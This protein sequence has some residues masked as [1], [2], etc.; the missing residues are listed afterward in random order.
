MH[1]SFPCPNPTCTHTFSP[2]VVKGATSLKCPCCGSVFQFSSAAPAAPAPVK[3]VEPPRPKP[4]IAIPKAPPPRPSATVP[5][6]QPAAAPLPVAA[7]VASAPASLNFNSQPDMVVPRARRQTASK[8][9]RLLPRIALVVAGLVAVVLTIWG[10]KRLLHW[11]NTSSDDPA[12]VAEAY[13]CQFAWPPKPWTRQP[14]IQQ[15]LHVHIA[16]TAPQHNA[17]V[18]LFFRDYKTRMPSDAEMLDEALT[19]LRSYLRRLEWEKK[20]N[21]DKVQ[22]A[23]HPAKA[24]EFQGDDAEEVTM[25]GECLMLAWRGYGYW[26]FSWAPHGELRQHEE[27]IHAEWTQVRQRLTLQNGRKGWAPKAPETET[28]TGTKVKHQLAALKGLW[29][30]ESAED[31][32]PSADLVL[33]G[34]YPEDPDRK[35]QAGKDALFQVLVLPKQDNLKAAVA[36]ARE[37]VK[38]REETLYPGT[39]IEAIKDKNDEADRDTDVGKEPGHLSKLLMKNTEE[40]NRFL[41]LAVVNRPE[42]VVVLVGD[43]LA[44]RRDFWDQEFT[45]LVETFRIKGR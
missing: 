32:D 7:P 42:G 19:R 16:M 43:C 12:R 20:P 10:V 14:G 9:K 22:L 38:K 40:L 28:I 31:F 2:D 39:K 24:F 45:T 8:G 36:A 3:K 34:H 33:K 30:R 26:F 4:S 17:S 29:T 44:E 23:G 21:E 41:F 25:H 27:P 6:A 18:A 35:P 13:N 5:V 1:A 15:N 37:Y 11:A